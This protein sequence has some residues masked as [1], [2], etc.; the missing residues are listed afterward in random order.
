MTDDIL[1]GTN[2]I[3][4]IKTTDLYESVIAVR[5]NASNICRRNKLLLRCE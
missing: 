5:N 2:Q 3:G 1:R 4:F